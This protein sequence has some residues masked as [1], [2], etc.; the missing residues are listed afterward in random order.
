MIRATGMN[1]HEMIRENQYSFGKMMVSR[2]LNPKSGL[3]YYTC[4]EGKE[5]VQS[6]I[7]Q[8]QRSTTDPLRQLQ[9]NKKTTG[10]FYGYLAPKDGHFVFKTNKSPEVNGKIG[11]GSECIIVSN[12]KEHLVQLL[13]IGER[14][15]HALGHDFE[16]NYE[17]LIAS[18]KIKSSIRVCTLMNLFLRFMNEERIDGKRW[19]FRSVE[20]YYT[21]HKGIT[22]E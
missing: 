14:L 1:L 16:M 18:R 4:E 3:L 6:V 10:P 7:D 12:I 8:I 5:C 20:A 15:Q 2:Y 19:F 11:R 21:G 13:S 22:K 17:T 9:V